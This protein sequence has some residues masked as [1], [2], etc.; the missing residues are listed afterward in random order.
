MRHVL[1]VLR[2]TLD[3]I[4]TDLKGCCSFGVGT[5]NEYEASDRYG[6]EKVIQRPSAA[7]R[8]R[9]WSTAVTRR[10]SNGLKPPP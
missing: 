2:E 7:E 5:Y 3:A 1:H 4:V 6:Q 8:A 9:P 10:S